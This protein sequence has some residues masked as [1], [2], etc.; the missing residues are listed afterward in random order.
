MNTYVKFG[1]E[2]CLQTGDVYEVVGVLDHLGSTLKAGHYVTYLKS[3]L[4]HWFLY[5][6]SEVTHS[7]LKEANTKENYILLFKKKIS[8]SG[9]STHTVEVVNPT[10]VEE[11]IESCITEV[12][13]AVQSGPKLEITRVTQ[14]TSDGVLPIFDNKPNQR[15]ILNEE[16]LNNLIESLEY[17]STKK[18]TH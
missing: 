7:S 4:G 16:E 18:R 15:N 3:D 11:P 10:P 6:D 12:Q 9:S 1:E 8:A 13:G 5:N 14:S 2:L 17:I